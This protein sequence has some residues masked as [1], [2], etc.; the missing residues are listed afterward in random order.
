MI[1]LVAG[2]DRPSAGG[3]H[4]DGLPI[5]HPSPRVGVVFQEPRLLPWLTVSDNVAFGLGAVPRAER[6]SR[7]ERALRAIGL[8]GMGAR[9]PRDLSGGQAQR[10]A[11]ARALVA[12]PTAL[13]LDEPFSALDAIT[14]A[15]LHGQLL[16]LWTE[17]RPT[18]LL[19]THD[20]DE[21]VTLADRVVVMR[22]KPGRIGETIALDLPRP[23]RRRTSAFDAAARRVYAALDRSQRPAEGQD[24][25]VADGA[26]LWW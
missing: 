12:R 13:L 21:A 7:T 11:L 5:G 10:V 20:V 24:A 26:G 2:L 25:A 16:D 4:L 6:V 18:L 3:V 15:A 19:A 23:R 22:P 9:W 17:R 1:R 8:P 14:R